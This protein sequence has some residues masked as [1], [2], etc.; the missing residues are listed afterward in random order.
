MMDIM[1]GSDTEVCGDNIGR[2]NTCPTCSVLRARIEDV[3]GIAKVLCFEECQAQGN[4]NAYW[5]TVPPGV[6]EEWQTVAR[7]V[8]AWIKEG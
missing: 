8:S 1:F 6:K 5:K 7:A 3:E 4:A 2:K